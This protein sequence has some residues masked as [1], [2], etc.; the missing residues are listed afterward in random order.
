MHAVCNG[1]VRATASLWFSHKRRHRYSI[2]YCLPQIDRRLRQLT[3]IWEMSRLP[4]SLADMKFWKAS[5]WRDW[6]LLYSPVVLKDILPKAYYD[7]WTKFVQI[8]HFCLQS[9]IPM[10]RMGYVKQAME[11]FLEEYENLYGAESMSYNAHLLLHMVDHVKEWGPLWGYSAY[12]FESINGKLV[13][14]VNGTRHAHLQIVEKFCILQSLP[15]I[16][17]ASMPWPNELMIFVQSLLKGYNLRKASTKCAD[18]IL[19]GKGRREAA[20]TA[21]KKATIGAFT[22]CVASVDKS[23]RKN[24]YVRTNGGVFGRVMDITKMDTEA[25]HT[26]KPTVHFRMKKFRV[27]NIF[28]PSID[29]N[30]T[31]FA[32]VCETDEYVVVRA[33]EVKKCIVLC[34]A[35]RTILTVIPEQHVLESV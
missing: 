1:F 16:V 5:E 26:A 20:C 25:C 11:E 33:S 14:F 18:V 24:S 2:G 13:R 27:L 35:E 9:S 30:S 29:Q 12:P 10:D 15:Q 28:L 32:T 3:P 7:N 17:M 31:G 4:R 6:L 34:C 8:M 19:Y 21:Y 23:R 22:Y